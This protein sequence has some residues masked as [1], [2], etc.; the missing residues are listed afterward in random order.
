[1]DANPQLTPEAQGRHDALA[2]QRA[3]PDG[4]A[5]LS[6]EVWKLIERHGYSFQAESRPWR[7]WLLG[8]MDS[9]DLDAADVGHLLAARTSAGRVPGTPSKDRLW[10]YKSAQWRKVTLGRDKPEKPKGKF[11]GGLGPKRRGKDFDGHGEICEN[12]ARPWV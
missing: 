11:D 10:S 9:E 3:K 5:D 7:E 6:P 4:R 12:A 1:V 2:A 8:C